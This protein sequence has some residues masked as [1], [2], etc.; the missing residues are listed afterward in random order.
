[1][2]DALE[3]VEL[4]DA[5][6]AR[7]RAWRVVDAAFEGREPVP[8]EWRRWPLVLALA[9]V[10]VVAALASPPGQ[11]VL[12]EIRESVGVERA[13]PA[14]F[15]L[16]VP[17]RLLVVSDEGAW[18]VRQNGSKRL[19]GSYSEASW[20]PFGRFVVASQANELAALE[21]DGDVRW[22]LARPNVRAPRWG[23]T[24][25]DT[26]I[27]YLSGE[28]LRVVAGDGMGDHRVAR[29]AAGVAPAWRPGAAHV[30][31]Y[32]GGDGLVR[33]V[34]ADSGTVLRAQHAA[35]AIELDWVADLRLVLLPREL[36]L[37]DTGGRTVLR[38]TGQFSTAALA[39]RAQAVA[40]VRASGGT[41][42]VEVLS[43]GGRMRRV[44]TGTGRF[45]DVA[46]SPDGRWLLVGWPEADQ[47]V[48][49]RA[50][51]KRIRAVANVS[52]QFRSRGFP[53]VEGWC[54][55]G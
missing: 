15:S 11:A 53:R 54:C 51:G 52:D 49:V 25:T 24:A 8:H 43:R 29:R 34:N 12:D 6:G 35:G 7:E 37:I 18:V 39:P 45:S 1:V 21:P 5:D 31:T 3:R 41:S 32:A 23:G 2:K 16:P 36:R 22:T 4:P 42:V 55:A 9:A 14:V 13:Q 19:L 26:R 10:V 30:L 46:W 28:A 48:F 50:D 17:G 38:R 27:A 44:F 33:V 47:W 20:S 40:V